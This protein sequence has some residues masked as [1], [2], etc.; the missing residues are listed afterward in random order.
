MRE[1]RIVQQPSERLDSQ[2]SLAN[3]FVPINPT[4][5]RL[6]GVVQVKHLQPIEANDAIEFGE[7]LGVAFLGAQIVSGSQQV[8]RIQAHANARRSVHVTKD[9]RQVLETMAQVCA[10]SRGVFE[11]YFHALPPPAF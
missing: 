5:A 7:G 4:A 8:A 9:R 3:V 11:D 1:S 10:L 2:T 6:L